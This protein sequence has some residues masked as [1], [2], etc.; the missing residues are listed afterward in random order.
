MIQGAIIGGIVGLVFYFIQKS[1]EKK[2][3]ANDQ[4][5]DNLIDDTEK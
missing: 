1:K 2:A 4:L 3:K 5:D